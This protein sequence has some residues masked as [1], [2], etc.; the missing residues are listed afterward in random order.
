M[1]DWTRTMTEL[2]SVLD[3]FCDKGLGLIDCLIKG[4]PLG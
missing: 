4:L 2:R 1:V 3:G